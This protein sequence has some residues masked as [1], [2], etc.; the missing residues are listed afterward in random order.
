MAVDQLTVGLARWL[1]QPSL[2]PVSAQKSFSSARA[3][4]ARSIIG[5]RMQCS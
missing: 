4:R 1:V 3:G 2:V 5:P